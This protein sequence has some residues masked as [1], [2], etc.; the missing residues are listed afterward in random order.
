MNVQEQ[1]DNYIAQQPAS[2]RDDMN[3]LHRKIMGIAPGSRLWFLDGRN[4]ENKVVSNPNVGYGSTSIKYANGETK[5][6]Y[7]I[8]L[9][10][11]SAGISVYL[12][13]IDDRTYLSRRYGDRLG[14]AKITGYCIRFKSL[15]DIDASV[16]EEIISSHLFSVSASAS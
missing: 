1:I 12:I 4:S 6:F 7:R 3:E 10:A 9:S 2:K 13:G 16:L 14:R 5:D 11:N 15:S 8:G